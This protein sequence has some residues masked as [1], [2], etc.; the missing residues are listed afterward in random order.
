M[1]I[2]PDLT[3]EEFKAIYSKVARLCV[4]I[5]IKTEKGIL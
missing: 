3:H 5:V 4:A 1:S 2:K